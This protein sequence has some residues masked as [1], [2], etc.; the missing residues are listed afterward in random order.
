MMTNSIQ[1]NAVS[2]SFQYSSIAMM[3][4]SQSS[5]PQVPDTAPAP[6]PLAV[7]DQASGQG[8]FRG[9]MQSVQITFSQ[10]GF[11]LNNQQ[12][13]AANDPNAAGSVQSEE[14]VGRSYGGSDVK[15][16]LHAFMHALIHALKSLDINGGE[17][18]GEGE[19]D[20]DGDDRSGGGQATSLSYTS[21][22]LSLSLLVG[23]LDSTT[24][25]SPSNTTGLLPVDSS[26]PAPDATGAATGTEPAGVPALAAPDANLVSNGSAGDSQGNIVSALQDAFKNLL[27]T[28]GGGS[29]DS[30]VSLKDFLEKLQENVD[31]NAQQQQQFSVSMTITTGSIIYVQ[32]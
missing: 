8:G 1:A 31:G 19:N 30:Q 3:S 32:A 10:F 7:S 22:S 6:A 21:V 14:G 4:R 2:M 17:G 16:A 9:L 20:G 29:S 18:A 25:S 13:D 15:E 11:S 26:V 24:A 28:L 5:V 23:N 27:D 12:G